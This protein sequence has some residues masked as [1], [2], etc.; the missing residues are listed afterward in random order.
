MSTR[1]AVLESKWFSHKNVSVRSLFDL[2]S[3]LRFN[4]PHKYHYEMAMSEAAMKEA[5]PRIGAMKGCSYLYIASHGDSNGVHLYNGDVIK[6][7]DFRKLLCRIHETPGSKLTGLHL[8]SCLVGSL[9]MAEYLYKREIGLRW[10][11]GYNKRINWISSSALDMLFFSE[12]VDGGSGSSLGLIK[13]VANRIA[14]GSPGLVEELGFGIFVR[15]KGGK[16][17]NLLA[18]EPD[19][20]IEEMLDD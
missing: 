4:T 12:L 3:D 8:G 9:A 13:Y 19:D 10:I 20:D 16:V 18:D 7:L 6:P 2:V 1:I 15:G 14:I 11:A 17:I 5:I